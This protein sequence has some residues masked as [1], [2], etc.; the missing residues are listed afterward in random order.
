MRGFVISAA[1]VLS[2]AVSVGVLAEDQPPTNSAPTA[3]DP[4]RVIC[5]STKVTGSHLP[6]KIC[7]TAREWEKMRQEARD[8]IEHGQTHQVNP[9]E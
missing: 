9:H 3:S 1:A 2:I 7:H 8:V 4:D 5:K 6:T